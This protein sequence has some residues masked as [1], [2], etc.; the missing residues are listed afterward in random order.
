MFKKKGKRFQAPE[1]ELKFSFSRSGGAGGQNVN[2]VETKATV[3][4]DFRNSLSLTEGQ[5]SL[6]ENNPMLKNRISNG[7]IIIYSQTER[8]QEQNRQKAVEVL[9]DL[10]SVALNP[11]TERRKTKIPRREKEKRLKEKKIASQKKVGRKRVE[12]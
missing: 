2:K 10:V 9:N 4:W 7:V 8:S 3:F 12:Y 1:S 11:P 6:I 5:K